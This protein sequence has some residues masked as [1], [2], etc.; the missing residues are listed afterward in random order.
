MS[1]ELVFECGCKFRISG[2]QKE[3]DGL[4]SID[5]HPDEFRLECPKAWELLAEGNNKGVFQLEGAL[6]QEWSRKSEPKDINDIGALV[7]VIRPGTLQAKTTIGDET[8]SMTDWYAA[9]KTG[10]AETVYEIPALKDILKDTYGVLVYQEQ[11]IRI[12]QE[13]AGYSLQEADKLRKAIGK[14]DEELMAQIKEPFIE[15]CVKTGIVTRSEAETIFNWI[16]QSSRYSFN[17]SHG[18]EYAYITF[19]TAYIKAHFPIHFYTSWLYHARDKQKPRE[20]ICELIQDGYS[21]SEELVV[22]PPSLCDIH[23]GNVGRFNMRHNKVLYG[24]TDIKGVGEAEFHKLIEFINKAQIELGKP[25]AEFTWYQFLVNV[26]PHINKTV[27]EALI[28]VGGLDFTGQYRRQML[29]EYSTFRKIQSSKVEMRWVEANKN[30]FVL[31]IQ[32]LRGLLENEIPQKGRLEK[33]KNLVKGLS[34]SPYNV[35]ESVDWIANTEEANLGV[36]ITVDKFANISEQGN[37]S[38]IDILRGKTGNITVVLEITERNEWIIKSG[39]NKGKKMG[40]LAGRDRTGKINNITVFKDVWAKYSDKCVPDTIVFIDG[41]VHND[42][43]GNLK[44]NHVKQ[45]T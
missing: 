36:A 29:L 33:V 39:K 2:D 38:V 11:S 26:T 43:P 22:T 13:I 30:N 3:N 1:D 34:S 37:S 7:S 19:W 5:V 40:K 15:G 31:L 27:S 44:V 20:E 14:K 45:C 35:N 8:R 23:Y 21:Q 10:K 32:L 28:N 18:I 9:R 4:P 6:G 16:R 42:D 41:Y 25:V 24:L 12:A 17:K